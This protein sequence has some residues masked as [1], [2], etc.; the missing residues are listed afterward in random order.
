MVESQ[1]CFSSVLFFSAKHLPINYN[2][3]FQNSNNFYLI[4]MKKKIIK[5]SKSYQVTQKDETKNW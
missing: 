2:W 3:D 5:I 1:S 4:V